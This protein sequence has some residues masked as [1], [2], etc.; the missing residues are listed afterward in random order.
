[1]ANLNVRNFPDDL[2]STLKLEAVKAKTSLREFVIDRLRE[3]RAV[4]RVPVEK[5]KP[6]HPTAHP[7]LEEVV[8]MTA[9]A[10]GISNICPKA[11]ER[12]QE[13]SGESKR[14]RH[15]FLFHAGCN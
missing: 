15:G 4:P 8:Q 13:A 11:T 5:A 10:A 1:M 12:K 6:M 14:C 9:K 3:R 2:M 7:E